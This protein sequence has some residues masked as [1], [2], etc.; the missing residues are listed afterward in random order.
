MRYVDP[1]I[2]AVSI[3]DPIDK[4]A[5]VAR[6]CYLSTPKS[7][8][9]GPFVA[10]LVSNRHLAML[11]HAAFVFRLPTRIYEELAHL[12]DPFIKLI[13]LADGALLS[14]NLRT[15]IEHQNGGGSSWAAL[16]SALPLRVRTLIFPESKPATDGSV[17]LLTEAEVGAL[18]LELRLD[19]Q[20]L[21]FRLITDRGVSH[22]LVRHRRCSFA[23]ESTRYCNY[24]KDKFSGELTFIRPLGYECNR[25][26]YDRFFSASERTYMELVARGVRPD[27]ARAV[28]PNA[29]KTSI[30]VS[31]DLR[32]WLHIFELRTAPS[33]HPDMVRVMTMV[34]D[35][36]N[37]RSIL[38]E[39][40][41][42]VHAR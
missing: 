12:T 6:N 35:Y 22:E 3:E 32:E 8:D 14:V 13:P 16:I 10:R 21:T 26:S 4:V 27:E 30:V 25:E 36:M 17:R 28:L 40:Y 24:A 1:E 11:E 15:L 5:A 20:H 38:P 9:E 31:A 18:P 23:Q 37:E 29:L 42:E 19:L 2:F 41:H 7:A 34:K 39:E 33:A